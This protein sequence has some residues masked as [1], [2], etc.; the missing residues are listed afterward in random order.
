[1]FVYI[2]MQYS[3]IPLPSL[4]CHSESTDPQYIE[5]VLFAISP[6]HI[7]VNGARDFQQHYAKA[8]FQ[9]CVLHFICAHSCLSVVQATNAPKTRDCFN[10]TQLL[11]VE[12]LWLRKY[13]VVLHTNDCIIRIWSDDLWDGRGR[14]SDYELRT[15]CALEVCSPVSEWNKFNPFPCDFQFVS[16]RQLVA[17]SHWWMLVHLFFNTLIFFF[18][19][20]IRNDKHC[21]DGSFFFC[22]SSSVYKCWIRPKYMR[23]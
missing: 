20:V 5:L 23:Q 9:F 7:I 3:V 8:I 19:P 4:V 2:W 18:R 14:G 22:H 16:F 1:M 10:R 12:L 21:V 11:T 6:L 13:T 15:A 17:R